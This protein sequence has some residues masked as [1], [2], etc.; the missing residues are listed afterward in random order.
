MDG[1][2]AGNVD[3]AER[4]LARRH[5]ASAS[6]GRVDQEMI[7]RRVAD[8]DVDQTSPR[9]MPSDRRHDGSVT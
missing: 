8:Q 6:A 5:D 4:D 2:P 7:D 3:R 9:R 1:E